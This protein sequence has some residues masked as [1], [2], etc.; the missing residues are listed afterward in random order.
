MG[1]VALLWVA[2]MVAVQKRLKTTA[3]VCST[4][5]D[6]HSTSAGSLISCYKK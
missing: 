3:L 2:I 6:G 5:D 1:V 4:Y